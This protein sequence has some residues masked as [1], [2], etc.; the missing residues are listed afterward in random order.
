M[1]FLLTGCSTPHTTTPYDVTRLGDN[2]LSCAQLFTEVNELQANRNQ[3][4]ADADNARATASGVGSAVTAGTYLLAYIPGAS[5]LLPA[6][7]AA[8]TGAG[9]IG[10][11]IG[12]KTMSAANMNA[13]AQYLTTLFNNKG[14]KVP[15]ASSAGK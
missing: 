3:A 11:P 2:N 14:C 13:R 8:T 4:T 9:A 10:T 15:T 5:L 1:L 7:G 12:D 6:V